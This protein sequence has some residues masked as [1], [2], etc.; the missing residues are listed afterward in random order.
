MKIASVV[1]ALLLVAPAVLADD[2]PKPDFSR[3]GIQKVFVVDL[4]QP[5]QPR[6]FDWQSLFIIDWSALGT[7]WHFRPLLAPLQG[8]VPTTTGLGMPNAFA[9]TGTSLPYTSRTW[10]DQRALS[11]ERRKVERLIRKRA[12]IVVTQ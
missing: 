7:R 10:R 3:D 9:L 2:A 1:L 12:H 6:P 4:Y 8:S 11:A 5:P